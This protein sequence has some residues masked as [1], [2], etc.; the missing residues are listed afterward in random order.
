[1]APTT[2]AAFVDALRR[3]H[4]L[5]PAQ[6]DEI[7]RTL[8]IRFA[9][10]RL[11]ARDLLQR[12][13]LTAFQANHLLQGKGAELVLGSYV[14]LD[15]LGEGGMGAVFK[16]RNWKLGRTVAVKLIRKERL[17][18]AHA[19]ARFLRE[20]RAAAR[21]DHP[22]IVQAHDA[23][24]VHGSHLLVMEYVDGTDLARH[25]KEHGP[26]PV[27]RACDCVRQAA[28]GLQHAFER[29][30]VHR[31][32]KPHNLLLTR[33]GV[34][35]VLDM[36]L[37]RISQTGDGAS[38]T[39]LT[40]EGVV[41][42]TP[43][44]IAPEQAL[45]S[46]TV[47]TRA[48]LY[49]LGCTFFFLL[50]GRV[51]FPG[52]TLLH[53]L[54]KHQYEPP[55]RVEAL[56]PDVPPAIGAVVRKL[57]AKDPEDRFQTPAELT[58]ALDAVRAAAAPRPP[59]PAATVTHSVT[60]VENPFAGLRSNSTVAR[61]PENPSALARRPLVVAAAGV[62]GVLLLGL[63]VLLARS[64]NTSPGGPD[65]PPAPKE[66]A[67]RPPSAAE[68]ARQ[69]ERRRV[70]AA[71][72]DFKPLAAKANDPAGGGAAAAALR[73]VLREFLMK[74]SGTPAA[75]RACELLGPVLAK[76]PSP[77]D[78]LDPKNVPQDCIDHW[79]AGGREP[80]G[81]LVAALG[82]HRGRHWTGIW[83]VAYSPNGKWI[84]S[85]GGDAIRLWDVA[86]FRERFARKVL[87]WRARGLVFSPDSRRLLAFGGSGMWLL[88]VE[89]G[90]EVHV[91][92]GAVHW[93][94]TFSADGRRILYGTTDRMSL[95][96]VDSKREVNGFA[97]PGYVNSVVFRDNERTA[98]AASWFGGSK[99]T[100]VRLWDLRTGTFL[101]REQPYA[102]FLV[103]PDGRRALS[104]VGRHLHLWEVETG[105]ELLKFPVAVG[106]R[107]RFVAFSPDG[108][109]AVA[110]ETIVQLLDLATGK[111]IRRFDGH[112][113]IV[114]GAALSPDGK[115]LVTGG[116]DGTVRLWD[117][118][119]GKEVQPLTGPVGSVH[120]VA[121]SP[122]TTLLAS[123]GSDNALRLWEF[124]E[125]SLRQ[126]PTVPGVQG[127]SGFNYLTFAPDGRV[128]VAKHRGR[129]Q[130]KF[131]SV[132]ETTLQEKQPL[133]PSDPSH[134][135]HDVAFSPDGMRL[136]G[137]GSRSE[138][139]SDVFL[140]DLSASPP[141]ERRLQ[142]HLKYLTSV[143]FSP[144]GRR[145][146]SGSV[147]WT[148]ILWD[149]E[150]GQ[151]LHTLPQS[152]GPFCRLQFSPDGKYL[153]SARTSSVL[154]LDAPSG[155]VLRTWELRN[156]YPVAGPV[157]HPDG[158]RLLFGGDASD[159]P[160]WVMEV[161]VE[162][163]A[164]L[165]EWQ[166]PGPVH[167]VSFAA[168]GRHLAT[169]NGNGTVYLFRLPTPA[170]ASG[171]DAKR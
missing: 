97:H 119:T 40:Q 95:W 170:G 91:F 83:A 4:L 106:E 51:P 80:P 9:E 66:T 103:S 6:L 49:S 71:E 112:R 171:P 110:G 156:H 160:G 11:L 17:D 31:D 53:K 121:F 116:A 104:G 134:G 42:G 34:V 169:A 36:G 155:R 52:G 2:T 75:T 129:N 81:E 33:T 14:L 15:K 47:D 5:E 137:A 86:P 90:K 38:S 162:S 76:L 126:G 128:L 93:S 46:H 24:E 164:R 125:G 133:E 111:E 149:V 72:E 94:A 157:F 50:T 28:L 108:A 65:A 84:A 56:R 68:R 12:G 67:P 44:Y 8:Q 146:A 37:A 154:L 87:N 13:W 21:L 140:W 142:G 73:K 144:D 158:K 16:A 35:K 98:L 63:I 22:N 92:P 122:D 85:A 141:Q 132:G 18:S 147:D 27:P 30:L 118:E 64:G 168:D 130:V 74:H 79:R 57:M 82:E 105:K 167:A 153:V 69:A 96:D 152:A 145:L 99:K 100:D 102:S 62:A 32:V 43:D 161:D 89:T 123:H 151:A 120:S 131:Y 114:W 135:L 70:A 107:V 29:G 39:S 109:R 101:R 48:D 163:G 159:K 59:A 26:L 117:V 58:R 165:R 25:V 138:N 60:A 150:S 166:L 139:P 148:L 45:D 113:G 10:P 143:A 78:Q 88:D 55:P 115:R 3:H 1:M 127:T 77:L 41:M 136:A 20:V 19:V 61:R 23:D 124:K 54:N 7:V